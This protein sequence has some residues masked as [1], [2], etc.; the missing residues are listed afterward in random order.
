MSLLNERIDF[1]KKEL[2]EEVSKKSTQTGVEIV[3]RTVLDELEPIKIDADKIRE[4][5]A[6]ELLEFTRKL[7]PTSNLVSDSEQ[8]W[9]V[10]I[11]GERMVGTSRELYAIFL[12]EKNKL[13]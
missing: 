3:L 6:V 9:C 11:D 8:K 2:Q 4:D 1:Y 7:K 12:T 10:E 13:K 5:E